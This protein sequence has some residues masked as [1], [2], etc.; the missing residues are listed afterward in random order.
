M[1]TYIFLSIHT[2][3]LENNP[4]RELMETFKYHVFNVDLLVYWFTLKYES[5]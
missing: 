3:S 4:S 5:P 2:T 1:I